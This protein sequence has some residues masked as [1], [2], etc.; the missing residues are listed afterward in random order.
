M[1]DKETMIDVTNRFSGSIGYDIADLGIHRHYEP[2]ETKTV[3][4]EELLKLSYSTGGLNLIKDCLLIHNRE[5]VEAL[6][7]EVEPEYYYS[8][9]DVKELLTKGSLAQLED[10]LDFAEDGVIDLV[11]KLAVDLKLN[12]VSKRKAIMDK[13]GFNV[14]KAIEINEIDHADE[15]EAP[16]PSK[17]RA[18]PITHNESAKPARRTAPPKY[19]VVSEL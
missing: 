13:T 7:G 6:I 14:T 17:R 3:T 1:L 12:D 5:A 9:E 11:K 19:K 15:E 10:C 18:A 4:Y 2:K 16:A 8:E